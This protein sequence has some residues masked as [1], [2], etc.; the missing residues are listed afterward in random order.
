[1][2]ISKA[3]LPKYQSD[4]AFAQERISKPYASAVVAELKGKN[5]HNVA[6]TKVY[7]VLHGI[8]KDRIILDAILD[9][10]EDRSGQRP[11]PVEVDLSRLNLQK[12]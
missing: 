5:I 8:V 4:L 6:Q 12:A 1:M 11:E 2:A 10:I 9:V 7:H 3:D